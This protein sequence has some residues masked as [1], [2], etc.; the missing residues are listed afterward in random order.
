MTDSDAIE[1]DVRMH[2]DADEVSGEVA[3]DGHPA[4]PFEGWLGLLGA[5]ER[6]CELRHPTSTHTNDRP[7][8]EEK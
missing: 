1:L 4:L 3:R 2:V 7:L 5:V 6:A 8:G